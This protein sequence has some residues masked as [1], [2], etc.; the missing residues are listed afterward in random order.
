MDPAEKLLQGG[1]SFRV[2]PAYPR[3]LG[4]VKY[5]CAALLERTPEGE[6]R[7]FSSAG[8]LL[9][10]GEIALL[11]ERNGQQMFVYKSKEVPAEGTLLENYR[12]FLDELKSAFHPVP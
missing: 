11:V 8:A 4:V 7:Q 1:F 6:W 10:T 9:E 3:H 2:F 12:R 5:N